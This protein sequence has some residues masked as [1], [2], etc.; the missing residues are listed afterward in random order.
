M[1]RQAEIAERMSS[2]P[3]PDQRTINLLTALHV[4]L[5]ESYDAQSM[6]GSGEIDWDRGVIRAAMR[7]DKDAGRPVDPDMTAHRAVA[8]LEQGR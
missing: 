4:G 7:K 2:L 3:T 8:R 1:L 6:G 5:Y